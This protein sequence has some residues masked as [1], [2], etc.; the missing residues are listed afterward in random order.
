MDRLEQL[1]KKK[2]DMIERHRRERQLIDDEIAKEKERI[3]RNKEREKQKKE[4]QIQQN[5]LALTDSA[6]KDFVKDSLSIA[7][8]NEK[9]KELL[10]QK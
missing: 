4:Q 2:R 5:D 8:L 9:L 3:K 7:E 6:Y 10:N 1:N